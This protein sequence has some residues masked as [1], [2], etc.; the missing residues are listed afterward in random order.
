MNTREEYYLN[1]ELFSMSE[2][3]LRILCSFVKG[4]VMLQVPLEYLEDLDEEVQ[5]VEP[6]AL[7]TQGPMDNP[8]S[9]D[10][11]EPQVP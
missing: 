2:M 1:F 10:H 6:G 4:H 3:V 8:A 11:L 5:L 9:L 7:E